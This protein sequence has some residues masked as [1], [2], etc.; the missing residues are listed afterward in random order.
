MG[1]A[2]PEA[3]MPHLA[4]FAYRQEE[5][6]RAFFRNGHLSTSRG[7]VMSKLKAVSIMHLRPASLPSR[8]AAAARAC[9]ARSLWRAAAGRRRR[10]WGRGRAAAAAAPC[11]S[12]SA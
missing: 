11:G 5:Q 8:A 4:R 2:R 10:R 1:H 9:A 6:H 12:S 3:S 7:R